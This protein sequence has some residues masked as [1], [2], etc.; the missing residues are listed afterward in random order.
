MNNPLELSSW[1]EK[2][3]SDGQK[4]IVFETN[5][6]HFNWCTVSTSMTAAAWVSS[7]TT[8]MT[9]TV[10]SWNQKQRAVSIYISFKS[11][12]TFVVLSQ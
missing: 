1:I 5:L 10:S 6:D 12:Y 3:N 7:V 9:A 4:K 8:T 2:N 11:Q